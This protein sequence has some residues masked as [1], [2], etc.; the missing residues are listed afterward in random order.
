VALEA[1]VPSQNQIAAALTAIAPAR[2]NAAGVAALGLYPA[3]DEGANLAASDL[4]ICSPLNRSTANQG[5]G[6]S[7]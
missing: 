4:F 6:Q 2:R 3:A 7:R 1:T 5:G